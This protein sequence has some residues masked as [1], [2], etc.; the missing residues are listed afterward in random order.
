ME[1]FKK[2]LKNCDTVKVLLTG[3]GESEF[4]TKEVY[5]YIRELERAAEIGRATEKA[6]EEGFRLKTIPL[7]LLDVEELISWYKEAE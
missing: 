3:V 1:D 6:F 7:D 5:E 4:S 2:A